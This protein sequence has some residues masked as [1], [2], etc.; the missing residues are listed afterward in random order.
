M[1]DQH[2]DRINPD[3]SASS[4]AEPPQ[5]SLA[6][7]AERA[8]GLRQG[9]PRAA[10][11]LAD[12][13]L[14][15]A[16]HG[17]PVERSVAERTIGLARKEL[18]DLDGAQRHL[19]RAVA[20]GRRSGSP[21]AL[22]LAQ[23]SLGYV[24]AAAGRTA[25]A[26]NAVTAALTRLSGAEAAQALMQRG[27][28][29]YFRGRYADAARDYTAAI[30]IAVREGE[31][32]LE[33]RARNNRAILP[34][35]EGADGHDAE[36]DLEKA[37]AIFRELGLDLAAAD[38]R[39]NIGHHAARTGDLARALH[40]FGTTEREYRRLDVPRPALVLDRFELLAAVPLVREAADAADLAVHELHRR[41]LA[42]D[43]AEALLAQA[44]AALLAG[45]AERAA[46]VAAQA[47]T[48]FRRQGR[49]PWGAFARHIELRAEFARG[50]R[51]GALLTRL[52]RNAAELAAT[53]WVVPALTGWVEAA[54]VAQALRRPARARELLDR[55]ARHR[56]GGIAA[57]R[58]AGWYA[59]ALRHRMDGSPRAALAALHRGLSILD[60]YR[61][62]LG[63]T[64]LRAGSST[65]G[66][67]LAR[68]GLDLAVAS[69]RPGAVLSWAERWRASTLR[70]VPALPSGDPELTAAL[71]RLRAVA[72]GA[73]D[74]VLS[75]GRADALLRRQAALEARVADLA[76]R[77][78]GPRGGGVDA[79]PALPA[80][81][82]ALGPAV[83]VE[84][85]A[86][87]GRLR[88][89]VVRDG[90]AT[91]HDLGP[92]A[93]VA[94]HV[95]RS[96]FALRRT[97]TLGGSAA[98]GAGLAHATARLDRLLFDPLRARLADRPL[99]VVPGS[100]LRLLTWAALPTCADRPVTV[101]PSAATWV[102]A[103]GR[104]DPA[105]PPVLVAGPRLPEAHDEVAALAELWPDAAVLTGAR[106]TV[107]AVTAAVDGSRLVHLAAH[108]GFRA[109]NPLFSTLALA[110]GPLF[111]YELERLPAA[112]G[113]V[114]ASACESG[115]S[116][117]SLGDEVM[118][119]AAVLLGQGTRTLIAAL[120]PV[121]AVNTVALMVDLHR[122]L[123]TGARPAEALAGAQAALRAGGDP[124]DAATAASFI[125]LG[126]G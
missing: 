55:A 100:A 113:C 63:A 104:P 60:E 119:F 62:S 28:V 52:D 98:A 72:R 92:A 6:E 58:A 53:G 121:P 95:R 24:L 125:C 65:H 89:V 40:I 91:L 37:A 1:P 59:T 5:P 85:L 126:A 15:A 90:R 9:D 42:S 12:R 20:V 44:R 101:A 110:D 86:H 8:L 93:E 74:A 51:T 2:S 48:R 38:C 66:Q 19:R 111:A 39:W 16:G 67:E 118:G 68:E 81:A 122:R 29:A 23:M 46:G 77:A 56:R 4:P 79:V 108:G 99:V 33:A 50:T 103:A 54:R 84:L 80:L 70:M 27:V 47:Y 17:H 34:P 35:G 117:T 87:A 7:L 21:R 96:R 45:D 49:L 13:V 73:E 116:D 83:L 11:A 112:P 64:E 26:H 88:A 106:A 76:R 3:T 82:G 97:V 18:N 124:V 43:L 109:D 107:G 114:V 32:L 120:L 102:R 41:G 105:G 69:G 78:G 57:Q 22:G 61:V 115:R 123:R 25:A 36:V 10:I 71:G 94:D 30:D 14:A 75:G 31:S